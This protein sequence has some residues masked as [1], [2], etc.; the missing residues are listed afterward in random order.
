LLIKQENAYE[1]VVFKMEII[2]GHKNG[3]PST[4]TKRF[5]QQIVT[6]NLLQSSTQRLE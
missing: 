2:V 4:S 1:Q 3:A 6:Y 5:A